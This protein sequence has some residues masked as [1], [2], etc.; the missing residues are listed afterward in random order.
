[1]KIHQTI[2]TPEGIVE[3]NGELSQQQVQFLIE[4]GLNVILAKG[5]QPFITDTDFT[6]EQIHQGTDVAQ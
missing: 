1:M 5:A 6:P 4:V 2:E 3:V